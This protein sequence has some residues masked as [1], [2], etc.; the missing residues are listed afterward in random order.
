MRPQTRLL[1]M[2]PQIRL[3]NRICSH[4]LPR[5][6]RLTIF[7]LNA[8]IRDRMHNM[9]TFLAHL[10]RQSLRKLADRRAAS[11]V[12]SELRTTA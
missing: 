7:I 10:P 6:L 1:V 8:A 3:T 11:A 9:H 5:L 12:R 4:L 2:Q